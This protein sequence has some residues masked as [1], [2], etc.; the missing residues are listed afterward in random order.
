MLLSSADQTAVAQS[1]KYL[2]VPRNKG[3]LSSIPSGACHVHC[4]Y[5]I[6]LTWSFVSALIAN[7]PIPNLQFGLVTACVGIHFVTCC[8]QFVRH[9]VM[10][11]FG[12]GDASGLAQRKALSTQARSCCECWVRTKGPWQGKSRQTA[13][14]GQVQGAGVMDLHFLHAKRGPGRSA[15]LC[16]PCALYRPGKTRVVGDLALTRL[17][18]SAFPKL[19]CL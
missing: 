4:F 19:G 9:S 3:H 15:R 8:P 13:E 17:V 10:Y 6:L 11:G 7:L 2:F 5:M 14:H 18:R 1:P 16:G 12:V